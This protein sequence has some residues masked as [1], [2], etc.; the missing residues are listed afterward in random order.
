MN[1]IEEDTQKMERPHIFM[2][3]M[4]EQWLANWIFMLGR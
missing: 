1:E 2:Y 4:N 3:S